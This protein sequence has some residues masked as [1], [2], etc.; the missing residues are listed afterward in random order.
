MRSVGQSQSTCPRPPL[1]L[2]S[3]FPHKK[4][5]AKTYPKSNSLCLPGFVVGLSSTPPPGPVAARR[6]TATLIDCRSQ[7]HPD[8]RATR[9]SSLCWRGDGTAAAAA[10]LVYLFHLHAPWRTLLHLHAEDEDVV[11]NAMAVF[12]WRRDVENRG[13]KSSGEMSNGGFVE[14]WS[15]IPGGVSWGLVHHACT[16]CP[17]H[18]LQLCLASATYA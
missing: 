4:R 3:V 12:L 2:Y 15:P 6:Q 7:T 13:E 9:Q 11:T 14:K 16:T 5:L 10:A 8:R 18:V 17:S 1:L